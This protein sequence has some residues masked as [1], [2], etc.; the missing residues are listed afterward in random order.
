MSSR[1]TI[2]ILYK[3]K[4]AL[5]ALKREESWD[6]FLLKLIAEVQRF[7]REKTGKNSPKFSKPSMMR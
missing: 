3:T 4:K 5:E 7:R 2:T 6:E 1:T